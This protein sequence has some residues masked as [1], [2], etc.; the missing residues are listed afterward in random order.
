MTCSLCLRLAVGLAPDVRPGFIAVALLAKM[1]FLRSF[2]RR[3]GRTSDSLRSLPLISKV[4]SGGGKTMNS[5]HTFTRRFLTFGVVALT[6][7]LLALVSACDDSTTFRSTVAGDAL[8][9]Q[10]ALKVLG[11]IPYPQDN[12][13]RQERISLGRLLFFDPILGGEKDVACGTCHHPDFAFADSRQFGAGVSGSGLGPHRILG[14]SAETGNPIQLE[15]RNSP[16]IFNAAFNFDVSG[17]SSHLGFQFWDGRL[18]GLEAQAGGPITSRV[19]M[20]GDAYPGT[21]TEAAD[22]SLD[23]V[24]NRLREIPE[25]VTRFQSAFPVKAAATDTA[26]PELVID[27]STYVRAIASYE[28]ELVTRNSAYDRFVNGDDNALNAVQKQGLELFYTTAKCGTCHSGAMFSDFRFVVQGVP[29]EG[30]GKGTVAGDDLG[31]AEHTGSP[32]DN[33]AFRTPTLR[34]VALTPP[35]MHDG[36]FGTLEEVMRFYNE[37]GQ[38]R[39]PQ[40]TNAMLEPVLLDSLHLTDDEITAVVE[41]MKALTDPG[42]ALAPW[43]LTVPERVPSGLMPVFGVAGPGSGKIVAGK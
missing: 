18:D 37:G 17:Q 38:P 34:N 8:R 13:P 32:A 30:G 43:M 7:S 42:T 1:Y 26:T 11:E 3:F 41:F 35:Y 40:V 10:F 39:H 31:R 16:T 5:N 20:R 22:A 28:R 4:L 9:S 27:S 15:P 29:Q 36:V 19:E 23:S 21:D 2:F 33:Y 24:I 6:M 14:V 12:P 25:Y